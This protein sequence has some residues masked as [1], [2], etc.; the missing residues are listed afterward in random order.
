MV[1]RQRILITGGS[2]FIGSQLALH[3]AQA[4]H[5]VSVTTLINNDA[6]RFRCDLLRRAGIAI[7]ETALDDTARLREA[8]CGHDAIIHLAA[9]QHEAEAPES[10]FRKVNVEGTRTLLTLAAR[11]GVKR[12]V[13]GSTIG[14]YGNG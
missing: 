4:G 5:P 11:E 8:L 3:A 1:A 14:V 13:H 7:V 10:H 6:E 9:A 2:G 12:V